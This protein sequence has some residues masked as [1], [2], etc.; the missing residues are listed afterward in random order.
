MD[1]FRILILCFLFI[2]YI[3]A[4]EKTFYL[5]SGDKIT[6]S[7]KSETDSTYTVE[8][9]FGVLTINKNNVKPEEAFIFLKSGDKLR[10]IIL[11]MMRVS[12]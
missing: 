7:I 6:G 9:S 4:Q 8:T 1:I 2:G 11:K 10:G 3:N 12:P 5:N